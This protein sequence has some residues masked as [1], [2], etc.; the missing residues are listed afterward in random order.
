MKDYRPYAHARSYSIWIFIFIYYFSWPG[1]E[2]AIFRLQLQP[3]VP[4]PCG[5][6][7]T[8][9]ISLPQE[10]LNLA[11]WLS[12]Q[13]ASLTLQ[14]DPTLFRFRFLSTNG[15]GQYLCPIRLFLFM[16]LFF[17]LIRD[18][19]MKKI[20][21][22][23]AVDP[24]LFFSDHWIIRIRFQHFTQWCGFEIIFSDPDFNLISDLDLV[25]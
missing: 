19:P 5:S 15:S 24:K 12:F 16:L 3:K 18:L 8:T 20:K 1:A 22:S 4:A 11:G 9:L 2:T 6:G 25:F 21:T 7:S 13:R 23:S 17:A 14:Q 10:F